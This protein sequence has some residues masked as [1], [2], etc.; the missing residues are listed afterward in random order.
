MRLMQ[1]AEDGRTAA[2]EAA[3]AK[4]GDVLRMEKQMKLLRCALSHDMVY[5]RSQGVSPH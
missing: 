4:D 2:S 3:S 5:S 1:E